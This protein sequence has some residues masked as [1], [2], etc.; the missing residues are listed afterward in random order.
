MNEH[1]QTL[2]VASGYG[3]AVLF[4]V[5]F[6]AAGI[7][8]FVNR[9]TSTTAQPGQFMLRVR[10][11]YIGENG[12]P[13]IGTLYT[14]AV[15]NGVYGGPTATKKHAHYYNTHAE[16]LAEFERSVL[17]SL[18]LG[19]STTHVDLLEKKHNFFFGEEWVSIKKRVS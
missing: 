19:E 3:F 7:T 11:A 4:A 10:Y 16:A 12:S 2:L 18:S 17:P 1:L 13:R 8:A 14:T 15:I 5:M 9:V 6:I